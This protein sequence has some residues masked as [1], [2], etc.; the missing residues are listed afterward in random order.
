MSFGKNDDE[1]YLPGASSLIYNI[2]KRIMIILRDGRH[3]VGVLRSFD[4]FLNLILE[5]ACERVILADKY[6]DI[7][8]GVYIVRGENIILLGELDPIAE[9][10]MSLEKVEPEMLLECAQRGEPTSLY[11]PV[12]FIHLQLANYKEVKTK[13]ISVVRI[14][15]RASL[16][17]AA[18]VISDLIAYTKV[19]AVRQFGDGFT[20]FVFVDWSRKPDI[21]RSCSHILSKFS[22]CPIHFHL[23]LFSLLTLIATV[24]HLNAYPHIKDST[25]LPNACNGERIAKDNQS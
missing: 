7:P 6:G 13:N 20:A 25:V 24:V 9:S 17:P 23:E 10:A 15:L 12:S 5:D 19:V 2:D 11:L 1:I 8:L 4:Q 18:A 3:L 22:L 16:V 21:D 14:N